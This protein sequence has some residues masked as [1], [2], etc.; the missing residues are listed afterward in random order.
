MYVAARSSHAYSL[1][2][3]SI[4]NYLSWRLCL[5]QSGEGKANPS[6]SI[7]TKSTGVRVIL[8]RFTQCRSKFAYSLNGWIVRPDALKQHKELIEGMIG[9]HAITFSA[10]RH[11]IPVNITLGR[12]NAIQSR[13]A[14][15]HRR[16]N[17]TLIHAIDLVFRAVQIGRLFAAIGAMQ[18]RYRFQLGECEMKVPATTLKRIV[19][20]I[21][22]SSNAAFFGL[23]T[24]GWTSA[25]AKF[26]I[27]ADGF[28]STFTTYT[29]GT[30]SLC[31]EGF[32]K[33]VCENRPPNKLCADRDQGMQCG[34]NLLGLFPNPAAT[35]C[36]PTAPQM[37]IRRDDFF[38]TPAPQ[39]TSTFPVRAIKLLK[40]IFQ[41]CQGPKLGSDGNK[42]M[43]L[44]SNRLANI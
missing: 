22:D 28:R 4:S 41:N 16:I 7:L 3:C 9:L 37:V 36:T 44:L 42:R 2:R 8:R 18:L 20:F 30:M 1:Y 17:A 15:L 34:S 35:G 11:H 14:N 43:R 24:A 26:A 31:S 13:P 39:A 29:T 25:T 5:A 10:T 21:P 32:I 6:H 33:V 40:V 27:G 19:K 23:A 12:I 38:P